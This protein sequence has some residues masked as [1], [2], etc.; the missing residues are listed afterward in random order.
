MYKYLKTL[1]IHNKN[2]TMI[3]IGSNVVSDIPLFEI[4]KGIIY[5]SK[6]K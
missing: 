6:V 1:D 5:I 4:R 2:I 3:Y